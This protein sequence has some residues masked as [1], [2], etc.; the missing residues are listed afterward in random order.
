MKKQS[1]I[2]G[3]HEVGAQSAI[4][5]VTAPKGF[6]A[7]GVRCGIK[8]E[9]KDLAL[10]YSEVPAAAAAVF[11]S[12]K[13]KAA[14][15]LISEEHILDGRI[16]AIVVNS[17]LANCCTGEQG[18]EDAARMAKLTAT[19][20]NIPETSV[21]VASTG[22]IGPR[23]HIEK[24]EQGIKEAAA[25]LSSS[26]GADAARAIMTTD[27]RPKEAA[28]ELELFGR[29]IT[30]GGIAKGAGMIH[31]G[32]AT[33]LAFITTDALI[34][35]ELLKKALLH[36]VD[37]SFNMITVDGDMSTNDMVAI[38]ANGL[39]TTAEGEEITY[40]GKE[41]D[42]FQAALD[43]LSIDLAKQI[44]ADGEGATKLL[45]VR[46]KG[47]LIE[48]DARQF[49]RAVAGSNLVKAAFYGCDPNVGRIMAA[50]G[51]AGEEMEPEEV[52][53]YFGDQLMFRNGCGA[54]FDPA[55][56]ASI[57]E[58]KE[59]RI[60]IDLDLGK[61]EATAWGCD[62]SPEYVKINAHYRT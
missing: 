25:N 56:V 51:Q 50:L 58:Q 33:M 44:P 3:T 8:A 49:A 42:L 12:N 30:L 61:A 5:S 52:D 16:Q 28:L 27:T 1:A 10:I 54:T 40:P 17:G 38:M 7:S 9:G 39:A 14:P 21:L 37:R 59:I 47:A 36:S 35:P 20:L 60:D 11:T 62:L 41:F 22:K 48:E 24:I 15:L 4:R 19:E 31:P 45:E 46:V 6:S 34:S 13:V 32:L 2:P 43:E 57:M 26:G 29:K 55:K 53:I 23:L 18:I